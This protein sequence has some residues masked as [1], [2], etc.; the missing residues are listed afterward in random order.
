MSGTTLISPGRRELSEPAG[1]PSGSEDRAPDGL[2]ARGSVARKP[3]CESTRCP[4]ARGALGD[5][6]GW[7][8][9][10]QGEAAGRG[11]RGA[12]WGFTFHGHHHPS[13]GRFPSA[14]LGLVF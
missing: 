14:A 9:S 5:T 7:I 10:A 12:Q 2:S 3:P 8:S 11:G 6:A 4:S 13:E 1:S